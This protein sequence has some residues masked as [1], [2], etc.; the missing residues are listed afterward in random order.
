MNKPFMPIIIVAFSVLIFSCGDAK[1][2][3]LKDEGK[4]GGPKT[5]LTDTLSN[6]PQC[7]ISVDDK[8]FTIPAENITT[9]YTFSDS[10][11]VIAFK[12]VGNGLLRLEVPNIFKCPMKV[13]TGYSS[14]RFKIAGTEEYSTEPT[15]YLQQYPEPGL[16]FNN[17]VDG[18]TKTAV[19]DNA[20]EI[21]AIRILEENTSTKWAVYLI[22][23]KINT[24]VFKSS[25]EAKGNDRNYEVNGSFVLQTKIYF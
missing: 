10:S 4:A 13:P 12:G 1:T 16:E 14:V 20:F 6:E 24:T 23:G 8:T 15:V 19:K 11:L 22:K 21:T 3:R 2:S 9:S 7:A 17:L 18:H 5:A 25:Y